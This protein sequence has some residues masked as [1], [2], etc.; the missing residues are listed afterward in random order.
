MQAAQLEHYD[1]IIARNGGIMRPFTDRTKEIVSPGHDLHLKH[2]HPDVR[3]IHA[4]DS[5]MDAP[6]S[7]I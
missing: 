3:R 2:F 5:R 6:P 7:V 4:A 1:P